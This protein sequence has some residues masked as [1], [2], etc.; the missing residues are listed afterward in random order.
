M[1]PL[2]RRGLLLVAASPL[3][4]A[5][6]F[7]LARITGLSI[8]M[9]GNTGAF[10]GVVAFASFSVLLLPLG[11]TMCAVAL[12]RVGRAGEPLVGQALVAS[13][14]VVGATMWERGLLAREASSMPSGPPP[15]A[16]ATPVAAVAPHGGS[17]LLGLFLA[18]LVVVGAAVI[19]RRLR[20]MLE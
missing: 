9:G 4:L 19:M 10:W 18:V 16:T 12:I 11:A 15:A 3:C 2:F 1:E 6:A 13:A 8:F 14:L 20:R 5:S 7:Y 17:G